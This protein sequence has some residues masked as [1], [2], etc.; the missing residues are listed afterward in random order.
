MDPKL[1]EY[2]GK[3]VYCPPLFILNPE[4]GLCE[5]KQTPKK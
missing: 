1:F 3:E 4:N 2:N 5:L